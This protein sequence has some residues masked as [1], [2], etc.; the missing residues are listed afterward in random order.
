MG[1]S[2]VRAGIARHQ[3][4]AFF[5]LAYLFAWTPWLLHLAGLTSDGGINSFGPL[6]AALLVAGLAGGR[7]SL[8]EL[9][10]RLVRW[11]VRPGYYL[12]AVLLPVALMAL[13]ATLNVSLFG[14]PAPSRE[15]LARWPGALAMAPLL[16][17]F[18]GPLGEEL[19][20]RGFALPRLLDR[21]PPL[22]AS[23]ILG[24]VWAGW[25]LPLFVARPGPWIAALILWIVF[26][27]VILTWL[28]QRTNGSVLLAT[29]FHTSVNVIG[30]GF[31]S[32][33]F[34]GGDSDRLYWIAAGLYGI[35]AA[36]VAPLVSAGWLPRRTPVRTER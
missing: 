22:R 20:W 18:D 7:A 25:H 17:V 24:L 11:R 32:P 31:V 30:G 1:W 5:F 21:A 19:G 16:L 34:S 36:I 12:I 8:R 28:Y 29:L 6:A 27:A 35:A 26:A 3:L 13:A 2:T 33:M 10:S 9:L 14:A 15:Q 23:V 4:T